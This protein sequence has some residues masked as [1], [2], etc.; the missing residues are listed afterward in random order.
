MGGA[1]QNKVLP[2]LVQAE[3]AVHGQADFRRVFVFLASSSHRHTGY[4]ANAPNVSSTSY[5]QQGQRKR[6]CTATSQRRT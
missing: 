2:R 3:L 6:V 1:V 5:P 4:S